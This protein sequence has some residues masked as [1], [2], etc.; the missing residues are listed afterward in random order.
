MH[1]DF[2]WPMLFGMLL[3]WASAL[4]HFL[5]MEKRAS[6][7]PARFII[8]LGWILILIHLHYGIIYIADVLGWD[9]MI[10]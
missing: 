8:I 1:G 6:S 7:K 2:I 3:L 10:L 4:L 9:F 5:N